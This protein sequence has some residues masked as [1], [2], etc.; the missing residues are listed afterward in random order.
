V[1]VERH[2]DWDGCY[3]V[4]DLGGLPAA[5]G[6]LTRWGAVVRSDSPDGLRPG[7][8]AALRAH[9]IGTIV[10]LRNDEERGGPAGATRNGLDVVHV[11]LDDLADTG[12]WRWVWDEG[13]DGTPL[14]YRPFL[15]RKPERCAAAV[16]AVAD[17]RP[18][19]VL[20]HCSI[21]RDRAGLVTML[22]LALAG[23][24]PAD[25]ADDYELSNPRL[26]PLRGRAGGHR[27]GPRPAEALASRNTTAGAV[28]EATLAAVDVEAR[29][30]AG[31][32]GERQ[33][34]AVR[35]RLLG[36]PAGPEPVT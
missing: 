3:N 19:G 8:W 35:D 11:P 20:V 28:V 9:G 18:G 2:L 14:Y 22:L 21:G 36:P 32:L 12:F 13:L 34:G 16:G 24:A 10:D 31:G 25:I 5:G 1:T 26:A 30:R 23:V 33:L 17:A 27:V 6:R 15:E 7:G 4:R 29:L